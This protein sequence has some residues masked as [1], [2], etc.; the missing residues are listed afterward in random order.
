[1]MAT[2]PKNHY[3]HMN[4]DKAERI[5]RLYYSR[6]YKQREL[7]NLFG[8]RQNTVSRIVSDMVWL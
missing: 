2:R 5:R 6:Q 8:I 7:A 1:M 3:R 4:R